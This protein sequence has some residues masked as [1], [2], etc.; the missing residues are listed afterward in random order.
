MSTEV[1]MASLPD[2]DFETAEGCAIHSAN[3]CAACA[4]DKPH[5]KAAYDGKTTMGPWAYMC[6]ICFAKYGVGLGTGK[7]QKLVLRDQPCDISPTCP[8]TWP[9]TGPHGKEAT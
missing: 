3:P 2:C 9:H 1:K 7:G 4:Y 5:G 8:Q 6:G